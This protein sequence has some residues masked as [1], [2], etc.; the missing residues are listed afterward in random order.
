MIKHRMDVMMTSHPRIQ[1]G[2]FNSYVRSSLH[3]FI[4]FN[5]RLVRGS[6][7]AGCSQ[8]AIGASDHPPI[9]ID[10]AACDWLCLAPITT[11]LCSPSLCCAATLDQLTD[12]VTALWCQEDGAC[13][14]VTRADMLDEVLDFAAGPLAKHLRPACACIWQVSRPKKMACMA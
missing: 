14:A 10:P 3:S 12:W 13:Q 9:A 8:L 7:I 4:R 11:F 2:R 6:P 5:I 1:L